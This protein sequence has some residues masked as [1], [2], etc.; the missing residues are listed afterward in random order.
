MSDKDL[1][2]EAAEAFG[3]ITSET[4][5]DAAEWERSEVREGVRRVLA[6]FEKRVGG[7]R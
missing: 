5:G 1:I 3:G 4:W 6:V 7:T 2:E